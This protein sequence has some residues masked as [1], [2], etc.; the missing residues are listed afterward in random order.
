MDRA[1]SRPLGARSA[2]CSKNGLAG[3]MTRNALTPKQRQVADQVL[4]E[5]EQQREHLVVSLSGAHAYGFPSPDSDLDLKAIH[6]DPTREL[7]APSVLSTPSTAG[8]NGENRWDR[9]GLFV[10]RTPL[11][12]AGNSSRQRKLHRARTWSDPASFICR[13]LEFEANRRS[14]PLAANPPALSWLRDRPV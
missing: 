3:I 2:T 13:S 1:S 12:A 7:L 6:I 5:E 11:G 4:S 10:E 14:Q 9:S 8:A